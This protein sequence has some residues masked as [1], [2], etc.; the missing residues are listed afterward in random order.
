MKKPA[1][2]LRSFVYRRRLQLLSEQLR[3]RQP[4][5]HVEPYLERGTIAWSR[6]ELPNVF[7]ARD[8]FAALKQKGAV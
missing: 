6:D 5:F 3:G 4:V 1:D 8:V 2:V 7:V